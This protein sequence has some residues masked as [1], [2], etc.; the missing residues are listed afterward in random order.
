MELER[1]AR[2]IQIVRDVAT[3]DDTWLMLSDNGALLSGASNHELPHFPEPWCRAAP[4]GRRAPMSAGCFAGLAQEIMATHSA[5]PETLTSP[6][7][8]TASTCR[9]SSNF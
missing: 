8:R 2:G 9:A 4:A 7:P 1:L 5:V 6:R 3:D